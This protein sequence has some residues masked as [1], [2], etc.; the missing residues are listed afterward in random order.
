ME[1]LEK[2]VF[3]V[4]KLVTHV[5]PHIDEIC[6]FWLLR[7]FGE[8]FFPGVKT[9]PVEF[10]SAG[11]AE[12]TKTAD[13]FLKE[14]TLLVGIGGGMFDEHP[15]LNNERKDRQCAATLVAEHLGLGDDPALE[16][17]MDFVR[18]DD[19]NGSGSMFDIGSLSRKMYN[20]YPPEVAMNWASMALDCVYSE[21]VR[22][23]KEAAEE[24]RSKAKKYALK[25]GA[26]VAVIESDNDLVAKFARSRRGGF[27]SVVIQKNS[28]GNVQVFS[29]RKCPVRIDMAK[30]SQFIRLE[31]QKKKG[32]VITLKPED[33]RRDG[34]VRGAE[35]WHYFKKGEMLFNGSLSH[36]DVPP[37]NIDLDTI[38][39]I[40]CTCIA[41]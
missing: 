34:E 19:L 27:A 7:T 12:L 32:K 21:Q 16:F 35:E 15:T 33:L 37:T 28:T 29:N 26:T 40:V 22:F 36:P 17:I 5:M 24:F 20:V 10:W 8:S 9:A 18:R 25:N 30:I 6:A 41:N 1:D 11:G 39:R 23:A 31:E 2:G 4:N 3:P 38:R 14:G 13:D